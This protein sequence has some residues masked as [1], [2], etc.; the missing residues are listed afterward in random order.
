MM[1]IKPFSYIVKIIV[2]VPGSGVQ[3]L[4]LAL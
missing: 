4:E 1:S 3:T 2:L